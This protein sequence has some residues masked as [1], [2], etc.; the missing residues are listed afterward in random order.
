MRITTQGRRRVK[1]KP[2]IK[3]LVYTV[4]LKLDQT[5]VKLV[6]HLISAESNIRGNQGLLHGFKWS[7]AHFVQVIADQINSSFKYLT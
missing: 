2:G 4:I 5:S 1:K 3:L 7:G 6:F